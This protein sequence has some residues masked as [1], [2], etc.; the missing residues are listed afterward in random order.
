MDNKVGCLIIHGFAGSIHEIEPLA[1]YLGNRGYVIKCPV[2]KGHTGRKQDLARVGYRDWIHSA[3]EDLAALVSECEKVII[4][5][6]SMGGLI[7]VNLALKYNIEALVTLNMPVYYWDF[8]RIV[9]NIR[10]DFAR[11][12]FVNV[13]R[14]MKSSFD[15]PLVS[16]INFKRILR[17][18]KKVLKEVS[19]PIFIAQ[20]LEDDTV[21]YRSADFI[22][23]NV[24]SMVK[25]I[26]YYTGSGHLICHSSVSSEVFGD[27]DTFIGRLI[28]K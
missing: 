22:Y 16:L 26:K 6:F 5:G 4:I 7:A 15:K 18:T 10:D 17:I 19:C 12:D 25:E 27:V 13:R 14:Y 21:Q 2:L 3:E 11:R 8:R 28:T 24:D 1:D 9:L 20:A 23:R